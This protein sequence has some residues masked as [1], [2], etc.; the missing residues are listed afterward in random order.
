[1]HHIYVSQCLQTS[2]A[3]RL[4]TSPRIWYAGQ[5]QGSK[6]RLLWCWNCRHFSSAHF[7]A[8]MTASW[9]LDV[10][11][12]SGWCVSGPVESH[13]TLSG[14]VDPWQS[15]CLRLSAV[16]MVLPVSMQFNGRCAVVKI[17]FRVS[18]VNIADQ[19][20]SCT[21]AC[22]HR[23]LAVWS[24]A[25]PSATSSCWSSQRLGLQGW[26]N[27][28]QTTHWIWCELTVQVASCIVVVNCIELVAICGWSQ[29]PEQRRVVH[30]VCAFSGIAL[31]FHGSVCWPK[32]RRWCVLMASGYRPEHHRAV[33]PQVRR[34]LDSPHPRPS[35]G[36]EAQCTQHHKSAEDV[37]QSGALP[38]CLCWFFACLSSVRTLQYGPQQ[39]TWSAMHMINVAT[40]RTRASATVPPEHWPWHMQDFFCLAFKDSDWVPCPE[41]LNNVPKDVCSSDN[42]QEPCHCG[43][44]SAILT[45]AWPDCICLATL[46][47]ALPAHSTVTLTQLS[48]G[49]RSCTSAPTWVKWSLGRALARIWAS[50]CCTA[51]MACTRT[52]RW[53]APSWWVGVLHCAVQ[54][55]VPNWQMTDVQ[56][57]AT[58]FH[59]T[60]AQD[61]DA[62]CSLYAHQA[63]R[64]PLLVLASMLL[65]APPDGICV[66]RAGVERH[67]R[68]DI[69]QHSP[70]QR[71]AA[72]GHAPRGGDAVGRLAQHHIRRRQRPPVQCRSCPGAFL[73]AAG[74][75]H[76]M[77]H[78]FAV[79]TA[80]V[81]DYCAPTCKMCAY[82]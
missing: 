56:L 66:T 5:H 20:A 69:Y 73:F 16:L 36:E 8:N 67:W 47:A 77:L 81:H 4:A 39:Q 64:S 41:E 6:F 60:C 14:H 55:V 72:E 18:V 63:G 65:E 13:A 2:E 57:L 40:P 37:C 35:G 21:R 80:V 62:G 19:Q 33:E 23:L 51:T 78:G 70:V 58:V 54:H 29:S 32:V 42:S 31:S 46:S 15:A 34:R 43:Y 50:T 30:F 59:D 27:P 49:H 1:M 24:C 52:T 3:C 82:A 12:A 17:L 11:A 71:H 9:T 7:V 76:V 38:R 75:M 28:R 61:P 53:C 22:T 68:Q 45:S 26:Q 25:S 74:T 44:G 10:A 79:Y 48:G